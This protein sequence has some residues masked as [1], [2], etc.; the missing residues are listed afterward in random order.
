M[1]SAA[2]LH[3]SLPV[4]VGNQFGFVDFPSGR[5]R[6][7]PSAP[8]P[9]ANPSVGTLYASGARRWVVV[10][11]GFAE[12]EMS[13]DETQMAAFER[14]PSGSRFPTGISLVDLKT[15]KSRHLAT[16]PGPAVR[17]LGYLPDGIYVIGGAVYRVDPATG[18]V[19]TI[20]PTPPGAIA[21][22]LWFWVTP[23]AAWASLIAGPNQSDMNPVQSISLS[24]GK[25]TTW[26]TAPATRSVSILG[27]VAPDEPLV[28]E[29]NREPYDHMTG[30]KFM[31]LTQPGAAQPLDFDPSITAWGITDSFGVW[32]TSGGHLWLYDRAGLF[33]IANVPTDFKGIAGFCR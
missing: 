27:F 23:F 7:D 3:C 16:L 11:Y 4:Q 15:N 12:Y 2:D 32:L 8:A 19:T 31:L 9:Q 26:Y 33:A 6:V 5:F 13:P 24:D 20:K 17:I 21:T 29:Y 28:A 14:D 25:V 22:D 18:R 30:V 1:R 10:F